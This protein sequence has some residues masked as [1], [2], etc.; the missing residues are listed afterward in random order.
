VEASKI[1]FLA[2]ILKIPSFCGV[3]MTI[4]TFPSAKTRRTENLRFYSKKKESIELKRDS[5]SRKS[6]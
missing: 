2:L 3:R 5:T 1:L 6:N 4:K